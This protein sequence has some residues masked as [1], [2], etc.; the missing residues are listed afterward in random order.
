MV[1]HIPKPGRGALG[2]Q[3]E[4]KINNFGEILGNITLGLNGFS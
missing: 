4:D 1:P 2:P 3:F